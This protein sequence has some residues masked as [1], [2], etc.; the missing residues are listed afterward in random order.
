[1]QPNSRWYSGSGIYRNVWLVVTG[2]IAVNHWGTFITTPQVNAKSALLNLT[3]EIKNSTGNKETIKVKESV[4]TEENILVASVSS[5]D[6]VISDTLTSV[7]QEVTIKDPLLW[8]DKNPNLY[9]VVTEI[10]KGNYKVDNYETVIGIR[11]FSFDTAKG[12]LLNGE[13]VKIRGVCDHH[14]LGCLGAAINLRAIE[15]QLELLREMGCNAIRTSHNPPAP[16][17]L[18]LCDR[19]GFIVMD[20]AFDM[21]KK[22]KT[23]FDYSLDWD[24]WHKTDL[25]DMI[26]RDRNHPSVF[27]WSIGN[28]I[29]EQRDS[30][31]LPIAKELEGIVRNLDN[32]RPITS[33][34]DDPQ[35]SNYIIRSGALDLIGYNYH[36]KTYADFP[37]I[38]PGKKFIATE[39]TSAIAT[40]GSYDMPSDSIRRWPDRGDGPFKT[41]NRDLSCSSYDN[42]SVPW[43]STHEETWKFIKKNYFMSGMFIWTGFDYLG[44]PTPY[45]WPARSSYFGI[46]DLSGFPKDSYYLYQSEWTEKNVLHIFPHWNWTP[47]KII[48]V[49]AYTNCDEVELFLNGRS[50]G[51]KQKSGDIMHLVWKVPFET[52]TL[53][54]VGRKA[55]KEILRQEIK[56]SGDPARIIL[57]PD[58]SSIKAD[59]SDLS[60]V[61]VTIVDKNNVPVP[62]A[63]NLIDFKIEGNATV[64]G[65][66]NGNQ[67]SMESFRSESRTAFHGMCLIVLKSGSETGEVKLNA[68]S[69]GL[70]SAQVTINLK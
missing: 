34:C 57:S 21:W 43:G 62:Y 46:L 2:K 61:K 58:R 29:P 37:E 31:G 40:R 32:T 70:E 67:V 12:F 16:E 50:L 10:K 60:F 52:G 69:S 53:L 33:A 36:E 30:T 15:R 51:I 55:G 49:W 6:L 11:S 13:S 7:K 20:E 26:L 8:S 35:P 68:S 28:E 48:D 14:D 41:G 25:E 22:K 45:P 1:M 66:D 64:A 39:T 5:G 54:G 44:E 59:G 4:Y 38:F 65:V 63:D 18:D 9:R 19:M 56:T 42:C 24:Q 27:I 23:D 17:L 3:A 47:G